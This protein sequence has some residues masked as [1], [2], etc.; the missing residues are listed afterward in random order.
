MRF[1]Q[2]SRAVQLSSQASSAWAGTRAWL[3]RMDFAGSMPEASSAAAMLRV[4][5]RSSAGSLRTVIACRSARKNRQ[6][7]PGSEEHTSELLSLMRIS[8]SFFFFNINF[9]FFFF[10]FFLFFF[11]FFFF[12][13]F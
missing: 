10:F 2:P 13:F 1:S 3:N 4:L 8:Y 6:S 7:P 11:F 9:F 5:A 12:F